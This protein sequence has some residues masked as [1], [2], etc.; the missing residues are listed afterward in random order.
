MEFKKIFITGGAGYCGSNLVPRLLESGYIV[1]VYD[2]MY[3]GYDFL[4]ITSTASFKELTWA[5]CSF[6]FC[7]AYFL[8]INIDLHLI[9]FAASISDFL[10]P[11]IKHFDISS[12]YFFIAS[13]SNPGFGF[14]K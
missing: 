9:L 14:R 3:F 4:N 13:L 7:S 5:I 2:I 8:L 11:T 12:L 10:S 6:G 1:T